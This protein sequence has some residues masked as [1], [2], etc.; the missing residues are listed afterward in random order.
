MANVKLPWQ[1]SFQA[2][3]RYSSAHKEAQGSHQG[4]WSVDLG[5]RKIIGDWSISLNCLDLFDS[6]KW[7][8][9]T[10]GPDYEQ[11]SERWRGGRTFRITV[12]YSFGNMKAKR[13][14]LNAVDEPAEAGGYGEDM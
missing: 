11:T 9:T 14:K 3:G 2:T 10:I 8:N 7:R 12:K 13:N 4:G 6:R 5:L 1:L